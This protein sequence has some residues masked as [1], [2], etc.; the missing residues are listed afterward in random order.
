MMPNKVI[1]STTTQSKV[2]HRYKQ[3]ICIPIRYFYRQLYY[4]LIT[5]PMK[6]PHVLELLWQNRSWCEHILQ[7]IFLHLDSSTIRSLKC[8]S[9][10][11]QD[12]IQRTL[13]NNSRAV[14]NLKS[15]LKV[16]QANKLHNSN[17]CCMKKSIKAVSM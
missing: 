15:K 4:Y 16:R 13:W 6:E 3:S 12:F 7:D 2:N 17:S 10:D 8:A 9:K 1:R 11:M 5:F 14:N